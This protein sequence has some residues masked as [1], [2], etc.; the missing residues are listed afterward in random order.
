MDIKS[1]RLRNIGAQRARKHF[2][3]S[4]M[5]GAKKWIV[6]QLLHAQ[7]KWCQIFSFGDLHD[8][9]ECAFDTYV[10]LTDRKIWRPNFIYI[11]IPMQN[12]SCAHTQIAKMISILTC[13]E[14]SIKI[15][16]LQVSLILLRNYLAIIH[17]FMPPKFWEQTTNT[18]LTAIQTFLMPN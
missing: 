6:R 3:A 15:S 11:G 18:S 2:F 16:L 7:T 8:I 5:V 1:S 13:F 4:E 12:H 14:K 10:Y 9:I 17:T